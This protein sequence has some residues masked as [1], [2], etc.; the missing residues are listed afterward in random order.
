MKDNTFTSSEQYG[1][2]LSYELAKISTNLPDELVDIW[3]DDVY[4]LAIQSYDAY[5]IGTKDYYQLTAEE[6]EESYKRASVKFTEQLIDG[7]V[8]KELLQVS[9]DQ[10]GEFLYSL[11]EKG[12]EYKKHWIDE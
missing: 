7:M 4:H 9:I 1:L 5:I 3:C 10:E 8:D 11:T 2:H 12:K 6:I